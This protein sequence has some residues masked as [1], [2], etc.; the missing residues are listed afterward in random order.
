MASR[1][2]DPHLE[3][4]RGY[5][6]LAVLLLHQ[7]LF[8][9]PDRHVQSA[10][11]LLQYFSDGLLAVKV[12]FVLSGYVI[13]VTTSGHS[14]TWSNSTSYLQRRAIRLIPINLFA[15]LLGWAAAATINWKSI[16]ATLLFLDNNSGYGALYLPPPRTNGNLWTLNYEALFYVLFVFIWIAR[17]RPSLTLSLCAFLTIFLWNGS[18][19]LLSVSCYACGLLFW[20]SGYYLALFAEKPGANAGRVSVSTMALLVITPIVQ[21]LPWAWPRPIFLGGA[22]EIYD[23]A[24]LPICVV[25]I[26]EASGRSFRGIGALR[27][28]SFLVCC[29]GI[30][31]PAA[32]L[33]ELNRYSY[34]I[35]AIA[36]LVT[37]NILLPSRLLSAAAWLGS[38]SFALYATGL[39]IQVWVLSMHPQTNAFMTL[40]N[41]AVVLGLVIGVS[42][43]L[44]KR[45]QPWV[46][47]CFPKPASYG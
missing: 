39:P 27:I 26:A 46:R 44:E 19:G 21:S 24:V 11:S 41:L 28:A 14:P 31:S 16:V 29:Q 15:V 7:S 5:A 18:T 35:V 22:M 23:L 43:F 17:P 4:I 12:F 45:V 36:S 30:L 34:G 38:I 8:P 32:H 1:S 42:W 2:S 33:T 9:G 47:E 37:S 6:A 25:L 20:L 13:G 10:Y 3:G 40:E